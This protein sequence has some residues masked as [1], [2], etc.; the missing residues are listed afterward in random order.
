M[1]NLFKQHALTYGEEGKKWFERIPSIIKTYEE[2]WSLRVLPPYTLTYNY[3][4]PAEHSDGSRAVLKIGYPKDIEFQSEIDMLTVCNGDGMVRLL[5]AD[6][7]NAVILIEEVAPGTPLSKMTD[8]REATKIHAAVMKRLWKP[9]PDNHHFTTIAKWAQAL[10]EPSDPFPSNLVQKAVALLEEL[11]ATSAPPMLT[12]ADLHHDNILKSDRGE[13]LAIDPKG[14]AAEPCYDTTAMIRNPYKLLH[15]MPNID[16]L[17]RNRI[18]VLS[19]EL[20]FDPE[21][22]RRWCFVQ[23]VLSGIWCRNDAR[24]MTHAIKVAI[25]L[26]RIKV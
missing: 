5:N 24:D 6:R 14:I 2:K 26:D 17:L 10:Y 7:A 20:G 15:E 3:I 23:T 18:R 1:N 19:E 22:I 12:H 25:A 21:R 13:W 4:A 11:L 9:L 8:D 16:D